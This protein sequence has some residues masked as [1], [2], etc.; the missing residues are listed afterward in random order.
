MLTSKNGKKTIL[1]VDDNQHILHTISQ[2][3]DLEGF[4]VRR[5]IHG[6]EA[7]ELLSRF[8]PDL[9]L[10]DI[11]MPVMDGIQFFNKLRDHTRWSSIPFI[12]LTAADK[13]ADIQM[14]RELGVEDYLTKPFD[15]HNLI[16]II[17]ARLLRA[18]ELKLAHIGSAYLETVNVLANTIEGRDSYNHYSRK[19]ECRL[20][21]FSD[22]SWKLVSWKPAVSFPV[23]PGPE[24]RTV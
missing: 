21:G 13:P 18:T 23:L 15:T 6:K 22:R 16:S 4:S 24:F 19:L 10:A 14:G 20:R 8:T 12:F 7:L 9:I 5:A 17:N 1:V 2:V 3:L 11:S